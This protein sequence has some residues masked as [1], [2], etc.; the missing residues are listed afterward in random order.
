MIIDF[1][2]IVN[3]AADAYLF[4]YILR[5]LQQAEEGFDGFKQTG[6]EDHIRRIAREEAE[7]TAL[8]GLLARWRGPTFEEWKPPKVI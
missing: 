8:S 5:I 6:L 7:K 3:M 1:E 2:R 4:R